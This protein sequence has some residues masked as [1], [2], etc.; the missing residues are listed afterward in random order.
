MFNAKVAYTGTDKDGGIT[1][2]DQDAE[3]AT[4]GWNL[5]SNGIADADYWQGVLGVNI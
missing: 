1:A 5:T 2:F 4:L 3:N